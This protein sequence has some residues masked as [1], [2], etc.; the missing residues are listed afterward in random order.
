MLKHPHPP[1][2]RRQCHHMTGAV[3]ATSELML[4]ITRPLKHSCA[5]DERRYVLMSLSFEKLHS[6]EATVTGRDIA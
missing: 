3:C 4:M 1:Q 5:F 2:V 6:A